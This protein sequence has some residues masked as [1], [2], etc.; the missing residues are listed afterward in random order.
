MDARGTDLPLPEG[1]ARLGIES[2]PQVLRCLPGRYTDYSTYTTLREAARA[3]LGGGA[4]LFAL[5]VT[6]APAPKEWDLASVMTHEAGHFLGMGHSG[7]RQA[8]M[9]TPFDQG[10]V[11]ARKVQLP[12]L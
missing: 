1:F 11:S 7:E 6:E 10:R 2:W 8:V 5:V 12:R 3:G 9:F 4:S